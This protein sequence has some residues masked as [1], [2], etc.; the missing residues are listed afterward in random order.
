MSKYASSI[1]N[2]PYDLRRLFSSLWDAAMFTT[3]FSRVVGL[4]LLAWL[5]LGSLSLAEDVAWKQRI[6]KQLP[7]LGHRNW[8]AVVD[9][10]YPLQSRPGIETIA[11]DEDQ[12]DVVNYVLAA[13][14]KS[15]H[16]RP[17]IF[18]DAELPFVT[19]EDAEGITDYRNEL[20]SVV[21]A[22]STQTLLHDEIIRKLDK[23][24]ETFHVLV[25]K[26]NMR[27]PYT[28]V[29]MELDCGYWGSDAEQR[30]RE[31]MRRVLPSP[32]R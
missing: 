23:S 13:L 30:L 18:L 14:K 21:A 4:S 2:S 15:P 16:V 22:Y 8:I 20:S 10:A 26:T 1:R 12:L 31:R 5:A 19:D 6:T 32:A 17:T 9:S 27:L 11:T 28:S 25:L 7:L 29:F 3:S 24:A